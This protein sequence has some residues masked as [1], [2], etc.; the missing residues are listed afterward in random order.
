MNLTIESSISGL[1]FTENDCLTAQTLN[2]TDFLTCYNYF[3]RTKPIS[4]ILEIGLAIGTFI[5][6]II[7][8]HSIFSNFKRKFT[9][10]D[11]ILAGYCIV[12]GLTGF[13]KINYILAYIFKIKILHYLIRFD[14]YPNLSHI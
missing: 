7:V 10:F 8:L 4:T 5:L 12:N 11:S 1:N 13:F 14:R 2:L 9:C 3:A 6:N